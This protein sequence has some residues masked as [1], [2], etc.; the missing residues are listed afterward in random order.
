MGMDSVALPA[1]RTRPKTLGLNTKSQL[2]CCYSVFG[3]LLLFTIGWV[4]LAQFLPPLNPAMTA[5][6]V[7]ALFVTHS[8]RIRL[9]MFFCMY[10]SL[11]L[12][13][14]AAVI[15]AQ[16]ARIEGEGFKVWT[17]TMVG[18]GAGNVLTFTFPILFWSVAAFRPDRAP[19]L[20][21]LVNDLAWIPFVGM[22]VPFLVMPLTV[23]IVG[24]LDPNTENPTF[25]RWACY[26]NLA[27]AV[28]DMPGG[29][30]TFFQTGV[31]AW[32]G[33]V[34]RWMG[35]SQFFIWFLVMFYLLQKAVRRQAR[36]ELA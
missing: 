31:F 4:F 6:Q 15:A 14:F 35:V 18:V 28:I 26:Y 10:S 2:L 27:L 13:P 17:Y 16:I 11:F 30:I 24:F 29:M 19:D 23:A 7:A 20:I 32:N 1:A 5:D 25:P 22:T 9:G 8:V 21:L 33:I 36:E 34:G 3:F 12:M